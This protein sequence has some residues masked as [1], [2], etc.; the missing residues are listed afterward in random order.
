MAVE[1]TINFIFDSLAKFGAL[2]STRGAT[3][4]PYQLHTVIF[5]LDT[6]MHLDYTVV[7]VSGRK[8]PVCRIFTA[9]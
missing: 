1:L 7:E 8:G 4:V 3:K 5:T 9:L 2:L 6:F